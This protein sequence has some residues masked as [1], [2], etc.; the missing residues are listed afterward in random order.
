MLVIYVVNFI[1]KNSYLHKSAPHCTPTSIRNQSWK[2]ARLS[3][4]E[5]LENAPIGIDDGWSDLTISGENGESCQKRWTSGV[6][7]RRSQV[8]LPF[9]P[10]IVRVASSVVDPNW[11]IFPVF[12]KQKGAPS[13]SSGFWLKSVYNA[14]HF[15]VSS[16]F[17]D[18]FYNVN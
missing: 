5:R 2:R 7:E 15:Y 8:L 10:L 16:Y 12:L 18:N 17:F 11:R 4:W 9:S 6:R 13:F 14:A 1:K 3:A